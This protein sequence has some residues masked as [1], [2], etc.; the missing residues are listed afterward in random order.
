M[1][2]ISSTPSG[3]G[4]SILF[5]YLPAQYRAADGDD[6]GLLNSILLAF[7]KVLL[8]PDDDSVPE[9]DKGLEQKIRDLA[10]Y[11][12]PVGEAQAPD[13]FLPW[14]AQ[15]V[16]LTLRADLDQSSQRALIKR[17]VSLYRR[18]GTKTNLIHLLNICL[19]REPNPP[20]SLRSPDVAVKLADV[21]DEFDGRPHYFEVRIVWKNTR[22][23]TVRL[24]E[25][26]LAEAVIAQEKP[27]HTDFRLIP[28]VWTMR[29]NH[30]STV[31]YDTWLGERIKI[32]EDS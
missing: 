4:R 1:T 30:Q 13:N 11:F 12:R 22:S 32:L 14:L 6:N 17:A 7:E 10:R 3:S 19:S 20:Q 5:D 23:T 16:A 26:A 8:G 25:I 21:S 24:R 2:P 18:R 28:I 9:N 29:I 27:A 31:G 15:W